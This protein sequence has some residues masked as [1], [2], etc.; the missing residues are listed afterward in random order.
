EEPAISS[1]FRVLPKSEA[2]ISKEL[3]LAIRKARYYHSIANELMLN[4][5]MDPTPKIE[6]VK[7]DDSPLDIAKKERRESG[8]SIEGQYTFKNAYD[9]FNTFRHFIES[10]N[11]LVFQFK[12]PLK[13]A[14]GFS[15]MDTPPY[16]IVINSEDNILARIFTLFHEYAHLLLGIPEL[17]VED[18]T[19][20]TEIE[21]WC[22][23]FASEFL[24]PEEELRKD[25]LFISFLKTKQLTQEIIE[26][27][28]RKFKVSKKALL[29]K[30][31]ILNLIGYQEYEEQKA[32]LEMQEIPEK[33][34]F[35]ILP[36]KRCIQE[37]GN[38]FI[39]TV[40]ESKEKGFITTQDM[41]EFLSIKLNRLDKL[42]RSLSQR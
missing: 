4:L 2:E 14:R 34:A 18:L 37:K 22:D 6:Q 7:L 5:N 33:K 42:E 23:S 13:D 21:R 29:T 3:R 28:S 35:I 39:L 40:L 26:N 24:I 31:R 32:K 36:E 30:L 27:L 41:V 1:S 10:K 12:F 25:E 15:L 17:Y 11:I 8:I 38:K 19:T 16:V 20:Y 9:G